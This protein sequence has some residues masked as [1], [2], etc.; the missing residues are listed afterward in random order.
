MGDVRVNRESQDLV[1]GGRLPLIRKMPSF[2]E[3]FDDSRVLLRQLNIGHASNRESPP[4]RFV[5]TC[6]TGRFYRTRTAGKSFRAFIYLTNVLTATSQ[7]M[8][9]HG[10][11]NWF[12]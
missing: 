6:S 4:P 3:L 2:V 7:S 8:A 12:A 5:E 10:S 1:R 11:T 9:S